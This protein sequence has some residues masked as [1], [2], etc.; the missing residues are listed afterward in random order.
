MEFEENKITIPMK[1]GVWEWSLHGFG[2]KKGQT[3]NG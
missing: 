2:F 3:Q 1:N